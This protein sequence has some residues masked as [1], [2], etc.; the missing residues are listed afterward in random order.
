MQT[1]LARCMVYVARSMLV[2]H[3]LNVD[4]PLLVVAEELRVQRSDCRRRARALVAE[5]EQHVL[6]HGDRHSAAR[7]ALT[8]VPE[9]LTRP[10]RSTKRTEH[11]RTEHKSAPHTHEHARTW[12]T[13]TMLT[14]L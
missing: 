3:L 10:L 11:K 14:V 7:L 9:R 8:K 12:P 1:L 2:A 5:Q 4:A 6:L 13:D